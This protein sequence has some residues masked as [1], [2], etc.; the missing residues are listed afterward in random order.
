VGH[1]VSCTPSSTFNVAKKLSATALFQPFAV[2]ASWQSL[3]ELKAGACPS[4]GHRGGA[5]LTLCAAGR[6]PAAGS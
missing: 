5:K 4:N 6:P 1:G 3:T 2:R